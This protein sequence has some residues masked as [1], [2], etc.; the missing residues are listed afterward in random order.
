MKNTISELKNSI[1]EFNSRLDQV[2]EKI[3]E[4]RQ[5]SETHQIKAAKEKRMKNNEDSLKDL[6]NTIKQTTIYILG[7]PEAEE[8]ERARKCI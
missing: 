8:R 7:F 6:M 4:L 1:K 2:K 3:R 5:G